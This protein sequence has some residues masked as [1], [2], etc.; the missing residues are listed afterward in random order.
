MGGLYG[1]YRSNLGTKFGV[2]FWEENL[3]KNASMLRNYNYCHMC[4]FCRCL[5]HCGIDGRIRSE[6][7]SA[8]R[9]FQIE[10]KRTSQTHPDL[11]MESRSHLPPA[12][13][14]QTVF[15]PVLPGVFRLRPLVPAA[16]RHRNEEEDKQHTLLF[17]LCGDP[18]N[19][20]QR[21]EEPFL[22]EVGEAIGCVERQALHLGQTVAVQ[23]RRAAGKDVAGTG[24]QTRRTQ[25][26][27][28]QDKAG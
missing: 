7:N 2:D 19:H 11:E 10:I 15:P 24:G 23:L 12:S 28:L 18:D 1:Y 17:E 5:R 14:V 25:T 9:P 3:R 22:P 8:E 6:Q 4:V 16:E 27:R 13:P 20:E 26:G 21:P